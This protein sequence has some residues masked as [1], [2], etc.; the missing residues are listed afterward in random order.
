MDCFASLAMTVVSSL[1]TMFLWQEISG[2]IISEGGAHFLRL[3]GAHGAISLGA[4]QPIREAMRATRS[5]RKP[6]LGEC[7]QVT[8]KTS[9]H[10]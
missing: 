9:L 10:P 6:K 8:Q 4:S 3:L 7:L 5:Q 1:R 2:S